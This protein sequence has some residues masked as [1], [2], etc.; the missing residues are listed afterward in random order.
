M[1]PFRTLAVP[2]VFTALVTS[3][4]D[5]AAQTPATTYSFTLTP[6]HE[7]TTNLDQG[8]E[9]G[10]TSLLANAGFQHPFSRQWVIGG[11]LQYGRDDW[12]FTSPVAFGRQAPWDSVNRAAATVS[13]TYVSAG[14]LRWT[15]AP[16]VEYAA[17]TG[18]K[19][20][21][22]FGYG[23]LL[24][25]AKSFSQDLTLGLGLGAFRRIEKTTYIPLL[26]VDW[27]IT[28]DL[29]LANPFSAGPAGGAGLELSYAFAPRW[30]VGIGGAYRSY[31]FR[32]SEDG[33]TPNG[34]G[35]YQLTP[36]FLRAGYSVDKTW[37]VNFYA[38]TA[39]GPKVVLENASADE[40]ASDK[41]GS[42][43]IVGATIS[44]RF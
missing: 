27:Q 4:L 29:R 19:S 44:A 38:G 11:S 33:S 37:Q 24:M 30:E 41:P 12:R 40:I 28:P 31:R 2:L 18:A 39:V 15:I 3:G 13:T 43:P 34:I 36:I 8:G 14:G 21:E 22:S 16:Q 42:T 5:A 17:E 23:A 6:I 7:G 32:L 26:I 20:S 10:S 25:A 35:Q 9:V 1:S